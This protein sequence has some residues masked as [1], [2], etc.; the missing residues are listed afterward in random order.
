[1]RD[2][3]ATDHLAGATYDLLER[4]ARRSGDAETAEMAQ[5]FGRRER[6][7]TSELE[8]S[9]DEALEVALLAE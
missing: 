4:A 8:G 9:L 3:I 1:V 7:A 6:G 5:R 2:V